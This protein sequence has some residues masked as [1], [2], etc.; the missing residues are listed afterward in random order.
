MKK[1][2]GIIG[3]MGPLA[4]CDLLRTIICH[5]KADQDQ[6]HIHIIMDC[7]PEI[8]DRSAA[9]AGK[10]PDPVPK[11]IESGKRL[12]EA[13]ADILVMHCNTVHYFYEPVAEALEKPLLHMP[14]ELAKAMAARGIKKAGILATD[15]TKSTGI[16]DSV[17]AEENMEIIYPTPENQKFLM[18]TI[19]EVK[20]GKTC[21]DIERIRAILKELRDAGAESI[22]IGCTEVPL[23]LHALPEYADVEEFTFDTGFAD[24]TIVIADIIIKKAGYLLK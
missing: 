7:N 16:Y 6:D 11:L 23:I 17:L 8:P 19:Y 13:G 21:R 20:G 22:I 1:T 12:E 15:G 2:V 5:T 4:S 10:G 9:I 24:S 14:R 18:E 3:G